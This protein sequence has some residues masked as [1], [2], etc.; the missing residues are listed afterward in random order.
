MYY[1]LTFFL[2][3]AVGAAGMFTILFEW[4][5]RLRAL[6][7]EVDA[8]RSEAASD[9]MRLSMDRSEFH[10]ERQAFEERPVQYRD[11][12]DENQILKTDLRNIDVQVRKL[13]LDRDAQRD[14]QADINQRV[15]SLGDRYLSD[16]VQWIGKSLT[17]NNLVQSQKKLDRVIDRCRKI[18]FEISEADEA[19]YSADMKLEY[20]RVVREAFAKEEQARIR[21]QIREQQK[22]ER[23]IER[24][25]KQLERERAAIQAALEAALAEAKEEHSEEVDRLRERLAEAEA[26]AERTKSQAELTKAG[27][28]YVISNIGSF[29][30]G[31]YKVG[32]TRRLEPELRIRELGDASVPFPFDIHM[33]ISAE[34]APKL[35][36]AIH[37]ALHKHRLNKINLRKEFFRADLDVIHEVV[38]TEHGEIDF[39]AEP[40][41]L[42]YRQSLEMSEQDAEYIETVFDQFR[43][44]ADPE[45]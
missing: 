22:L 2:G 26:K 28:V 40:E 14:A 9:R 8:T 41:A 12:K 17:P 44:E 11:L 36:N 3:A 21:A 20:E 42:D 43:G 38:K 32:L 24:E 13:Q 37:R 6:K 25:L 16:N 4:Q 19:R 30:E 10:A 15:N 29:G 34:D 23:E 45:D 27:H 7:E 35:E 31:V 33:M 5:R 18:G 1:A 39:I